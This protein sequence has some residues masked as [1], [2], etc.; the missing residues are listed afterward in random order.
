MQ[1]AFVYMYQAPQ[2]VASW[3]PE[4]VQKGHYLMF[5]K[6]I[7]SMKKASAFTMDGE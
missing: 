4:P 7:Y 2:L 6:F 1:Q 3:W 5:L